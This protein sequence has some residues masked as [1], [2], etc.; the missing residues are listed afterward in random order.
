MKLLL[1][2]RY[3]PITSRV[4]FYEAPLDVVAQALYD[5]RMSLRHRP[6]M[7]RVAEPFPESLRRLQPLTNGGS[8]REMVV[9]TRSEWTAL[10]DSMLPWPDPVGPVS[11]LCGVLKCRGL[12]VLCA[13]NTLTETWG[14][15]R[16]RYG[17]VQ[18]ELFAP[19]PTEWLNYLRAISAT[20]D[21]GR[22]TFEAT[23][24]PQPFEQPERY[25]ARRVQ[26]RFTA[27]MLDDYCRALGVR[28]FDPDFFGP[29]G[30][31]IVTKAPLAPGADRMTLEQAQEFLDITPQTPGQDD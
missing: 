9:E 30:H 28:Y 18:F 12:I 16:G 6:V 26:D 31:L 5:W 4:G 14:N 17:G 7:H 24:T 23:G 10:F 22:W 25:T 13:P 15:S 21:G 3:A 1:G 19:E 29:G 8:Q 27:D 20:N 11:Y 2:D